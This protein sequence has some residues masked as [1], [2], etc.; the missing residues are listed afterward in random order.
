MSSFITATF[1]LN[2]GC[3]LQIVDEVEQID[4]EGEDNQAVKFQDWKFI[5]EDMALYKRIAYVGRNK[6]LVHV[7]CTC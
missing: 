4:L 2:F 6:S 7:L 1:K 5:T 3:T